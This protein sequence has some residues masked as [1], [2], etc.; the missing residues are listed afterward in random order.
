VKVPSKPSKKALPFSVLYEFAKQQVTKLDKATVQ[1]GIGAAFFACHSCKYLKVPRR[2]MKCT[3][4]MCLRNIR[5]FMDGQL[6]LVPSDNLELADSPVVTFE[7]HKND[8]KHETVVHGRTDDVNLCPVLQL[9]CLT[10]TWVF[11]LIC[12][13]TTVK[14][15]W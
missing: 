5:L 4:N 9:A 2:E 7:M 8:Q 12:Y 10:Q 1:L 13:F 14:R 6:I 11:I 15:L 3:K